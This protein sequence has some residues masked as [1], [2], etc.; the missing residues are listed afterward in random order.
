MQRKALVTLAIDFDTCFRLSEPFFQD[1]ASRYGYDYLPIR[2]RKINCQLQWRKSRCNLHLEKFQ[3]GELLEQ[4]DRVLY[5]DADVLVSPRCPDIAELVSAQ[6][7]G[8][9]E[10]PAGDLWWKRQ[11]EIQHM[12]K[13]FGKLPE[14][15]QRYFNA[16][17][18]MVS[19]RHKELLTFNRK[20]LLPGRWP[21]QTAL[22]YFS[23]QWS[24]QKTFLDP[25]YNF[26][27]GHEGWEQTKTRLDAFV[28]HYAG[29]TAK[30]L[31]AEDAE[32]LRRFPAEAGPA[33]ISAP[34]PPTR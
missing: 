14:W 5:F 23:A 34:N 27:P 9:V 13:R 22:N 32:Q 25:R 16:G 28:I 29:E 33:P 4:Y 6:S 20:R 11:A 15:D 7:V 10:D 30:A 21:D 26:L 18:L 12:E 2:S 31:M 8:V 17:M 1:F 3:M 24:L 19:C